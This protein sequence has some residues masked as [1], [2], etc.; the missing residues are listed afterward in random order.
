MEPTNIAENAL[1]ALK[2]ENTR[3]HQQIDATYEKALIEKDRNVKRA[4]DDAAIIKRERENNARHEVA[5]NNLKENN[6]ILRENN[7]RL[8]NLKEENAILS[9]ALKNIVTYAQ[10]QCRP[11]GGTRKKSSKKSSNK[12]SKK[13]L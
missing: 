4:T 1:N 12:S 6:E 11:K 9:E 10:Q 2:L 13:S 3:L 7:K 8:N 5:I